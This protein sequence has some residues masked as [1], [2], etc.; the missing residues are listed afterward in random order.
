MAAIFAVLLN[1]A[2]WKIAENGK[3][4]AGI[5]IPANAKPIVKFAAG[6]LAHFLE[7]MT[8][9]EFTVGTTSAYKTN[10]KLGFGKADDLRFD[11]SIIRTVGNDIEIYGK[12]TSSPVNIFYYFYDGHEKGT[13]H[14]V[15]HLLDKLGVR[16][17]V[18]GYAHV[19]ENKNLALQEMNIRYKPY[20]KERHSTGMDYSFMSKHPD[21]SDYAVSNNG[22]M[23]DVIRLG[24]STRNLVIGC[25]SESAFQLWK[26]V[27]WLSDPTR[28]RLGKDGVRTPK[29]SCWTHPDVKALWMRAADAYFSGKTPK[30]AGFKNMRG[31][32]NSWPYPFVSPH[33]FMIDPYDYDGISDG[34]CYCARCQDFR[35]KHPCK[36][37]SEIMWR[38]IADVAEYIHKK[39][40]GKKI[41]TL[42]YPPKTEIP[43]IKLPPN[44]QVKLCFAGAKSC[45]SPASLQGDINKMKAWADFT[46]NPVGLW[47]YH[48]IGFNQSMP[49][50]VETY[51]RLMKQY[52]TATKGMV[53]GFFM[54]L[55][56]GNCTRIA[57]D[58]YVFHRLT[59]NPDLNIEE[60]VTEFCTLLY[61]PAAQDAKKF[62]DRLEFLFIDFWRKTV[63]SDKKITGCSPWGSRNL[64]MQ[65]KLWEITYTAEE[66]ENLGRMVDAIMQKTAG[67]KHE[68][69]AKLLKQ[70]IYDAMVNTRREVIGKEEFRASIRINAAETSAKDFPAP[71]EWR[72]AQVYQMR[73][74]N[75]FGK[76]LRE[77]GAFQLMANKDTLFIR[78]EF[79]QSQMNK[80][81]TDTKRVNG[82]TNIWMDNTAEF[83]IAPMNKSDIVHQIVVN[84]HGIWASR[85]YGKGKSKWQQIDG[86]RVKVERLSDRWIT[87]VAVPFKSLGSNFTELRFNVAREQR[88]QGKPV[89]YSTYSPLALV[90]VWDN[91]DNFGT[92]IFK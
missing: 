6:E 77:P 4:A 70:Y 82:D 48:L 34:I 31:G 68:K 62:Y 50:I 10:F 5:I 66:L 87:Q 61:G 71:A 8:G 64:A 81:A 83:F 51:P 28:S 65:R 18:P 40:P 73:P 86:C 79:M 33:E 38:V 19:P 47:L 49:D 72:K 56:N 23:L 36:D 67:T 89:E 3:A 43:K 20:Y 17:P 7:K 21:S 2:E 25:H 14:G 44:I 76:K 55:G 92:I 60:L 39:Y 42:V 26:D 85:F 1:G 46:G 45:L 59:M 54:E 30:Q 12:D 32:G 16:F 15:Y 22:A 35:K 11:E 69:Y 24:G 53:D 74:A 78:T 90:G 41:T 75:R 57:L 80:T 37:D 84:D 88:T 29:Y 27:E 9:A 13:L 91:S 52:F 63:P 58:S